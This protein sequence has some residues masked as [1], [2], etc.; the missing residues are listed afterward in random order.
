M[1][2]QRIAA[3]DCGIERKTV[4]KEN[5]NVALLGMKKKE[6]ERLV[7][8]LCV[9]DAFVWIARQQFSSSC[10]RARLHL[11]I[12]RTARAPRRDNA[13]CPDR[14]TTRRCVP[15]CRRESAVLS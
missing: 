7:T 1:R 11:P 12:T 9:C 6:A 13:S 5:T 3:E 10:W 14:G 4:V 15:R 8:L 2:Q